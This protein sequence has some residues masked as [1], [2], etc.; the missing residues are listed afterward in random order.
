[1]KYPIFMTKLVCTDA[2]MDSYNKEDI[3]VECNKL[4]GTEIPV[5]EFKDKQGHVIDSIILRK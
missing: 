5:L 3:T 1:M 2:L 4:Q